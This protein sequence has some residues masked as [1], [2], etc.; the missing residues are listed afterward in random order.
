MSRSRKKHNRGKTMTDTKQKPPLI[1]RMCKI[2]LVKYFCKV[3]PA[4]SAA[5]LPMSEEEAYA[6]NMQMRIDGEATG[7]I[8]N[9]DPETRKYFADL[10]KKLDEGM[11]K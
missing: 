6:L 2:G 9:V 11:L 1:C 5:D 10:K 7:I 3:C 8:S 4:V